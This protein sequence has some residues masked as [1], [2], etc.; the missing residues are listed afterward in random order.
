[1]TCEKCIMNG[2]CIYQEN[3][4]MCPLGIKPTKMGEG[5]ETNMKEHECCRDCEKNCKQPYTFWSGCMP[6]EEYCEKFKPKKK[7]KPT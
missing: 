1:M 7:V 6:C 5:S 3:N 4:D 2:N